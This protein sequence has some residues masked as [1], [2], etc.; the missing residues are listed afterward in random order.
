M[1]RYY[2]ERYKDGR[3]ESVVLQDS[4]G[5]YVAFRSRGQLRVTAF[6]RASTRRRIWFP[7]WPAAKELSA[8][9]LDFLDYRRLFERGSY[10][11]TIASEIREVEGSVFQ[12]AEMVFE[13]FEIGRII[14]PAPPARESLQ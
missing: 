7:N 2:A 12:V 13:D 4:A 11:T 3:I 14:R 8:A 5:I 6:E 1:V 9:D 10:T